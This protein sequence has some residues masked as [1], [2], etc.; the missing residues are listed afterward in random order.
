MYKN[1]LTKID[2]TSV[3]RAASVSDRTFPDTAYRRLCYKA[4]ACRDVGRRANKYPPKRNWPLTGRGRNWYVGSMRFQQAL[5]FANCTV[6]LAGLLLVESCTSE[7]GGDEQLGEAEQALL[8][9]P[10]TGITAAA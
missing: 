1:D 8:G 6:M 5:I 10:L 3:V 4:A 9:D 2:L 7:P